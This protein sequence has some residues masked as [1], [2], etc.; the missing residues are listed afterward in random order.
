MKGVTVSHSGLSTKNEI[1]CSVENYDAIEKVVVDATE[2]KLTDK[3][4]Y[5]KIIYAR[6]DERI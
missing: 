5:Y 1:A 6:F 2:G 3:S 4:D